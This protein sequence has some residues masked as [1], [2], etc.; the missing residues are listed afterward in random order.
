MEVRAVGRTD[1]DVVI[2]LSP[3]GEVRG[4]LVDE[5]G[6]GLAGF[7]VELVVK[8]PFRGADHLLAADTQVSD[9]SGNYVF[10]AVAPGHYSLRARRY[11]QLR[12]GQAGQ[13]PSVC[14]PN[15][16]YF[17]GVTVAEGTGEFAVY[18]RQ[19][20]DNG[21]M[22]AIGGVCRAVRVKLENV[23]SML[24]VALIPGEAV[25]IEEPQT[26]PV[27]VRG[28]EKTIEFV[29]LSSGEYTL[30]L[31]EPTRS[32]GIPLVRRIQ[33]SGDVYETIRVESGTIAGRVDGLAAAVRAEVILQ[34]I[35]VTGGELRALVQT[36]GTF[37]IGGVKEGDYFLSMRGVP[38]IASIAS[39][40]VDG[41]PAPRQVLHH[42][43]ARTMNVSV[44]L[45]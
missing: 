39:M 40:M 16:L 23:S 32:R 10:R 18:P 27:M 21:Q 13:E 38:S 41:V 33:V 11:P 36:D 12:S 29:A 30:L 3:A 9:A 25:G 28:Q 37:W 1:A 19:I 5:R 35:A 15:V 6:A 24:Q 8:K 42:S 31:Q 45:R 34:P 14:L 22:K 26:E 20:T 4:Q 44:Q 17:P 43:Q 2:A 7:S